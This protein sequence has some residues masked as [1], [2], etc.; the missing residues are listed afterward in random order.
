[1]SVRRGPGLP[2]G[3]GA[4]SE[5]GLGSQD[6]AQNHLRQRN[7]LPDPALGF[8]I[9]ACRG[10]MFQGAGCLPGRENEGEAVF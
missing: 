3:T 7:P 9:G 10:P 4:Q 1:M 8:S 6:G 2:G 5:H